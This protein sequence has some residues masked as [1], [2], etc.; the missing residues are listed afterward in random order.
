MVSTRRTSKKAKLQEIESLASAAVAN[1]ATED[2]VQ[3]MEIDEEKEVDDF[4][5][6]IT[7]APVSVRITRY[8]K[9]KGKAPLI[10]S[11]S[12]QS[13]RSRVQ[14]LKV[15]ES[16]S[17]SPTNSS[18]IGRRSL[19]S[20][21]T[22]STT[23]DENTD[24]ED[25]LF[26]EATSAATPLSLTEFDSGSQQIS[27]NE[28]VDQLLQEYDGEGGLTRSTSEEDSDSD[29]E[30]SSNSDSS[31]ERN[32]V[33]RR[34]PAARRRQPAARRRREPAV[35]RVFFKKKEHVN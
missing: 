25:D 23:P 22:S 15:A 26:S 2:G 20:S 10:R 21:P 31:E 9:D 32:V 35:S 33:R 18:S 12:T 14:R 24:D 1:V 11:D 17:A 19:R 7:I 3:D 5:D 27:Q 8:S 30:E 29:L 28:E 6:P 34:V 16:S 4:Q 13:L